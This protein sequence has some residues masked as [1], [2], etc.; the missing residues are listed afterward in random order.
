V[1]EWPENKMNETDRVEVAVKYAERDRPG[2][3]AFQVGKK[4]PRGQMVGTL[5]R[6]DRWPVDS[7][8]F[9]IHGFLVTAR[10]SQER[11]RPLFFTMRIRRSGFDNSK[12]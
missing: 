7:E 5:K 2:E 10:C 11:S 1:A 4:G 9:D 6:L 8:K 12:L 3:R